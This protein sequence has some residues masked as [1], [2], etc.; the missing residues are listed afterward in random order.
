[1]GGAGS[2]TTARGGDY[3]AAPALGASKA[4]ANRSLGRAIAAFTA[5]V[6]VIGTAY[7][8]YRLRDTYVGDASVYLPYARNAAAGHLF[9]FNVGE[10]SSGSTSPLWALLLALPY[11]VGLGIGGAKVLSTGVAAVAF[12]ATLFAAARLTRSWAAGAAGAVLVAGTMTFFSASLYESGLVVT[13]SA[14]ALLVGDG[15]LRSWRETARMSRHWGAALVA[16]WAAL[17]LARPD[18]AILVGAHALALVTFASVGRRRAAVQLVGLL[19]I[20]AVPSAL[21]FG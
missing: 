3:P 15:V 7:A 17:P 9:Q 12:L 6:G 18:A 20:A 13:L 4:V 10:F 14:L 8:G 21:Y 2:T 5:L 19:A 1:M 16:L 11:L